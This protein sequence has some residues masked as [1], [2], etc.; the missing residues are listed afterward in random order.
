MSVSTN[1]NRFSS[2]GDGANL[3][4]NFPSYFKANADMRVLVTDNAGNTSVKVLDVDYGITGFVT[5]GFGYENG[6]DIIFNI[7]PSATDTVILI[8]DPNQ[9]QNTVLAPNSTYPPQKIESTFDAIVLI[10]QRIADVLFSRAVVMKDG[11]IDPFD[12]TLPIDIASVANRGAAMITDPNGGN[13]FVMGPVLS[14]SASAGSVEEVDTTGGNVPK[15]LPAAS[16]G[17]QFVTFINTTFGGAFN[18]NVGVTGGDTLNGGAGDSLGAGEVGTYWS[19][20][21]SKWYKIN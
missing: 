16:D 10:I 6:A 21:T 3:T 5:A 20:G 2:L 4:F 7:A 11:M 8:N 9:L 1:Q 19:N 18:V 15:T 14:G 12:P 13:K 17:K